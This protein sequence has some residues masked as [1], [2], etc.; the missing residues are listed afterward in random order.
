MAKNFS[1]LWLDGEI[2]PWEEGKIPLMSH[3]LHYG[4]G[5]FEGVRFYEALD[6]CAIFRLEDHLKRLFDS[7][8]FYGLKIP[9]SSEI[10]LQGCVDLVKKFEVKNGYL[11]LLVYFDSGGLNIFPKGSGLRVMIAGFKWDPYF[12]TRGRSEGIRVKIS[13]WQKFS[14]NSLPSNVKVCGQYVN[15]VLASIDAKMSGFDEAIL[16]NEKGELAEGSIQ[17]LFL[18]KDGVLMTND[19]EDCILLGITRETILYLAKNLG[20]Q[21]EIRSLSLKDLESADEVFFTGTASE[22]LP[23]WE[24]DDKLFAGGSCGEMTL[25]LQKAYFDGVSGRRK[26]CSQFLTFV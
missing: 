15:S 12:G 21:T 11:R 24:V 7:A 13:P 10:L 8:E 4:L 14:S 3:T 19:E 16:L 22:V 2:I 18:V 6:G 9:F 1:H 20:F 25:S 5:V 26:D 17:N 23:I